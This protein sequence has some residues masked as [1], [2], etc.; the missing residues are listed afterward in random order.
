MKLSVIYPTNRLGGFD[1]MVDCLKNQTYQDWELIVIDDYP[2]RNL[3]DYIEEQGIPVTHYGKSKE[4]FYKDTPFP[5]SNVFN[6]G[7]LQATGDIA[8]FFQDYQ[9]IPPN[10][11]ERWNAIYMGRMDTLITAIGKEISYIGN[12]KPGEI[13]IFDPPFD[14]WKVFTEPDSGR[15]IRTA[16]TT[17]GYADGLFIPGRDLIARAHTNVFNSGFSPETSRGMDLPYEFF[18][19]AFPMEFLE[20]INGFDE[21]CDYS[22]EFTHRVVI[23]QALN[24]GYKFIVDFENYCYYINHRGW[25]M[26]DEGKN[27]NMWYAMEGEGSRDKLKWNEVDWGKPNLNNF[28]LKRDRR[29]TN[30]TS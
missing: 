8:V 7:L 22:G 23:Q 29:R 27:G 15:F 24:L 4:K 19:G 25:K 10:S 13:S 2:G 6:S 14:G 3:R 21:R 5:F 26:F 16:M 11:L 28:D 30:G 18:Y 20:K 12:F 1:M 9:W 17:P